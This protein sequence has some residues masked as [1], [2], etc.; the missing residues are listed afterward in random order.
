METSANRGTSV[1]AASV[2]YQ[3]I[4]PIET[5]HLTLRAFRD[6]DVDPLFAIQGNRE[7]MR[8]TYAGI[9]SKIRG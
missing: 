4:L 3:H 6:E 2:Q 9:T 7:A 5:R 1:H 8:Y